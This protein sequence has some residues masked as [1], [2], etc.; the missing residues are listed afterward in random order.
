[1]AHVADNRIVGG[2][3]RAGSDVLSLFKRF[4]KSLPFVTVHL[5]SD[6][7]AAENGYDLGD[8]V[9]VLN[10]CRTAADVGQ[11]VADDIAQDQAVNR[12]RVGSAREAASLISVELAPHRVKLIDRAATLEQ[13]IDQFAKILERQHGRG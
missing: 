5:S 4:G 13:E 7:I 11:P 8:W 1:M 10:D 3:I 6:I 9:R 2:G 12:G